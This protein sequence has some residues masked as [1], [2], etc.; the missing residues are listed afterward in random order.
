M[1]EHNQSS[2]CLPAGRYLW[3][4]DNVVIYTLQTR[5]IGL[6]RIEQSNIRVQQVRRRRHHGY[7][8]RPEC[9][10]YV[11][12]IQDILRRSLTVGRSN[13]SAVETCRVMTQYLVDSVKTLRASTKPSFQFWCALGSGRSVL[14]CTGRFDYFALAQD[15]RV[16]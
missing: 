6:N 4:Q 5:M 3:N 15:V 9:F 14:P 2:L 7:V 16:R 12:Q 13:A 8:K 10:R 11:A 1:A